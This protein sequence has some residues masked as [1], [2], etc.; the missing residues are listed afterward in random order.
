V[1][2]IRFRKKGKK[3]NILGKEV[4]KL[5]KQCPLCDGETNLNEDLGEGLVCGRCSECKE[6]FVYNKNKKSWI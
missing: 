1:F 2:N 3:D 5:R 6:W 4:K